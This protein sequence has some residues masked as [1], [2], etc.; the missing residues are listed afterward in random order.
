LH[1]EGVYARGCSVF[2]REH[3]ASVVAEE[4][5]VR[6]AEGVEV[7][8]S[9]ER[10]ARLRA[11]LLADV[12]DEDD[13][14]AVGALEL[15]EIGEEA[16]HFLS[17]VLVQGMEA[18]E[19][20]EEEQAGVER[21]DRRREPSTLERV[22]EAERR[23]GEEM[24]VEASERDSTVATDPVDAIADLLEGVLGQVDK[25]G[26]R[27]L[28]REAAERGSCRGDGDGHVEPKPGLAALGRA[29]DNADRGAEPEVA[30]EPASAGSLR[31]DVDGTDDR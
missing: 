19:W 15:A 8:G 31:H 20:V 12:V 10:L 21:L 17:V 4:V 13:G 29:T 9:A 3:E 7:G 11:A 28:G 30:Q 24:Q 16:G 6:V 27:L 2:E 22:V 26:T 14:D 5:G 25:R 1:G 18:H 23:D